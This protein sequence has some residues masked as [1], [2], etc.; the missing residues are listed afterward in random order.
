MKLVVESST[1]GMIT[2]SS[3]RPELREHDPL[4]LVPRVAPSNDRPEARL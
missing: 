1:P 3:G 2:R 4:V